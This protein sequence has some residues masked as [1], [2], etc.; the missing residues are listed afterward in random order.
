[1]YKS[2]SSGTLPLVVPEYVWIVMQYYDFFFKEYVI[3]EGWY[4]SRLVE[5]HWWAEK[6][7]PSV[8]MIA[9][10]EQKLHMS[11]YVEIVDSSDN[12]NIKLFSKR[13]LHLNSCLSHLIGL[14]RCRGTSRFHVCM[15]W[16]RKDWQWLLL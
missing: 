10:I 14:S 16:Y 7:D 5:P 4:L 3:R 15:D 6:L 12:S 13:G 1:M 2:S 11:G 9:K 8:S